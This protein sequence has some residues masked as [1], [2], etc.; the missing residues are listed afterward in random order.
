MFAFNQG[1]TGVSDVSTP[2]PIFFALPFLSAVNLYIPA[3]TPPNGT[4]SVSLKSRGAGPVR[5]VN[6]PNFPSST[7]V[8]TVQFNDFD[9]PAE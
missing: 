2:I 9:Q 4:V 5:T 6:F 1:N 7:D 3:S 8:A